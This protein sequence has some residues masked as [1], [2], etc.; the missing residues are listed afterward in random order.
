MMQHNT[1]CKAYTLVAFLL[2]AIGATQAQTLVWEENFNATSISP[3]TWTYDFGN[4][5]ERD[6]GCGW[7]NSELEYYTSRTDNAR[8][9]SGSLVIEA[10]REAFQGSAFTSARL[11][12]EGRMHF[13]YG[14]VE[15]RIKLPNMAN[16]L[17][18][19]FWTLG[20]I[21]GN[22]PTIGEIDM[23]EAGNG[24]AIAAGVVN[25]QITS[26][27]HWGNASGG[28]EYTSSSTNA[29]V[30]L[31]LDY[32]LY[33]MVWTAQAITMYLDNVAFYT[34]DIS[35]PSDPKYGEFHQPHFLLLNIAVGGAYTGILNQANITAPLPGKMYVDYVKLY[36]NAGD[37]LDLESTTALSGNF[38]VMT[39]NTPV[40]SALTFG[41]DAE[42][43]YWNN[44]T[45]IANP[46]PFEGANVWAVHANAGNW[47]GMG[48][49]NNYKNL[50]NFANGALRFR[51]KSTYQGQFKIGIKTGHGESWVNFA[52]NTNA[53]G[54]TRNGA[55]SEVIIPL[56]NFQNPAIGNNIDLNSVKN[57]FMFAGDNATTA[58]DFYFDD[59]YYSGGI[60]ANPPPTV[61]ITA[62]VNN[63]IIVNPNNMIITADAADANGSVTQVEF[64]NGTTLLGTDATSPYSLTLT[65]PSVGTYVLTAKAT[66]NENATT[67]SSAVTV[68]VASASNMP[69]TANITSPTNNA[70]F[71]TPSSITINATATDADGSIF[72]V[73]FYKDA[74]LLSTS[75][76]AP[77]TYIWTGATAGSYALTVKATDNGGLITTS[78]VVN[79]TVSNPIK[80]TVSI[81]SPTNN[82]RFAPLSNITINA[83][84][85]DANGTVTQVAF[86]NGATLLGTDATS[87]Y[88]YTWNGVPFG[89]Y[90]I[91]AV[92]TDNDGNTTTSTAV[93]IFAKPAACTGTAFNGDY[94]YEVYTEAG[95]VYFR[96]HPLA[97]ITGSN[98]AILQIK[99]GNSGVV[100]YTMTAASGDFTFS[101][102][103]AN[104]INTS[105][106]FTYAVPSGGERNSSANPHA[107]YVGTVCTAGEPTCSITSPVEA[108]SFTAPA[109]IT[110]DATSSDAD[111]TVTQVEFYNGAT[112]LGTDATSP[113]SYTWAN[114]A[115]GSYVLTAKATD[116]SNITKVSTPVNIVVN[117]PSTDGFCGTAI[118]GDY[119]YKASTSGGAVTIIFHPLS[120]IAGC[121]SSLIYIREGATGG[122]GGY[123]MTQVGTDFVF[124]KNIA[125]GIP[126]SIYFTYNTPPSGERNSSA[127]PHSYTVGTNCTGIAGTPP[128]VA[129]TSPANNASY[130]EPATITINADA[131][132]ADGTITNVEFYRGATLIGSDNTAPYSVNWANA[133]AGNYTISAKATDNS[134]FFTISSLRNIVVN[135]DN[136]AG[137]CGT[138]ANGDYSYR[139]EYVN[140]Q[141]VIVFHPL[142]ATIGSSSALVFVR[143][144][145]TG[146]YPGYNMTP[147]G[148]D[149]KFTKTIAS[150]IPLSIYFT[151]NVPGFGDKNS[152]ATPHSYTV[153]TSCLTPVVGAAITAAPVPTRLAANVLSLFS[154][155]YTDLAGTDWF[156]NWSQT[157]VV[158]DTSITGNTTKKFS[159]LNYQGT[160]FASAINLTAAG[161]TTMH[162]DYWSQTVNSFDVFLVN[163]PPLTQAEQK[164]TFTPTLS[165][166]NSID[167]PLASYNT[168]NLTGI[169]QIKWEGRPS[170]GTVYLDNIYFW[171]PPVAAPTVPDVAAPDPTKLPANVISLFSG[172]YTNLASTDWFPNWG[173]STVVADVA[174]VGNSTKR[175][176]NLNYQGTQFASPI[177]LTAAGMTTMHIDYWSP[178]VN[179]F[180]VFLV[181]IPPLT[182]NE[183]KVTLTPT[184]SGWNSIDIPLSSYNTLNLTGIGQIKWEGRPSG[185]T[186]Y[187]DNIYFW[188]PPV[189]PVELVDF[190]AKLKNNTTLLDWHTASER[191]NKAFEIERSTNGTTFTNIG[192]VKGNGTTS[193]PHD[194]TFTDV[195]PVDGVNYYRLRQI[196]TDGK[197]TL[198]KVVS[199][200]LGKN[201]LILH[202]TLVHDVLNIT[203]SD[204]E[205]GPLSIFNISG[206]LVA[207]KTI[208][209]SQQWNVSGLAAGFYIVRSASGAAL[210]FVKD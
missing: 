159:N 117:A 200:V 14:T 60:S 115:A 76:T 157:T 96:F 158:A 77:Y 90:L 88:S 80:P 6:A 120:P 113:Y 208:E 53:F 18:P 193:T 87:P 103:I 146:G 59:V 95:T 5:C 94:S 177:N 176:T 46:V 155:T 145:A 25:R 43:F 160:Q 38:G 16:G 93:T 11:K 198:S 172:V 141:V 24:S 51:Y 62:P 116:N 167:I 58:A 127:N 54:L 48:V 206:Q 118:N 13:K 184:L 23:M 73:E 7:G 67:I 161:M 30:D 44:L 75:T 2:I 156:P 182:Q 150:G 183:Q 207:S 61:S 119:K 36:Q 52:A 108:A 74:T 152:S 205:R 173:Q 187:L 210:R 180:D 27:A 99:E 41:T 110:I 39:D 195:Q 134:G 85:A 50:S 20:T 135:I 166:W 37:V 92:A 137:F 188:K 65:A 72:K 175:F 57:A 10:K 34:L 196:D 169:G 112:L 185:G 151:Y 170:G 142:G 101:K 123:T 8:I 162:V 114:V 204:D 33:K 203:V 40:A 69:P 104:G 139:V 19:A 132:D 1:L 89:E 143:E 194:Y 140:G 124:T 84:A 28:H 209:R 107:Y 131:T 32:H 100:G 45:N 133:A 66:D 130:T 179:S 186:V 125:N 12:T 147:V 144:G 202:N 199:V 178:T 148:A 56:S 86:Y 47:F 122:Y 163:I 98:L 97:P 21:G 149:F 68:F 126:L 78:S 81:T 168:L 91:T 71:L 70:A 105:F 35:N 9:E 191:N 49:Q 174:I 102:A 22:W 189:I 111:G 192:E 4:G 181:N 171:K 138:L 154:N 121:N 128:T 197:T 106:Y 17:W 165:G 129:L 190:K 82:A 136:S 201:V 55:W 29:A 3:T 63:A 26:A 31:S 42:L 109:S 164:V 79:I 83:D 153:G 15:A 64:Y